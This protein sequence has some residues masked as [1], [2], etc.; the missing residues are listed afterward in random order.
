MESGMPSATPVFT[1]GLFGNEM[2]FTAGADDG[3]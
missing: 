2:P 3:A 1:D